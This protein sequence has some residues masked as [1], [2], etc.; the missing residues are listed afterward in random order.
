MCVQPDVVLVQ[1]SEVVLESDE[2][3]RVFGSQ[4]YQMAA[5]QGKQQISVGMELISY[6]EKKHVE[7]TCSNN[8]YNNKTNN[9]VP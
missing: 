7:D 5:K 4:S 2:V 9:S 1:S 6:A 8:V 3:E